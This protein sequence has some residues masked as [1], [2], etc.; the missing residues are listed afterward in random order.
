MSFFTSCQVGKKF[1]SEQD[2][3]NNKSDYLIEVRSI[4]SSA[5][6]TEV[7]STLG[8]KANINLIENNSNFDFVDQHPIQIMCKEITD[9]DLQNVLSALGKCT[10]ILEV[11]H[12]RL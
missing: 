2:A 10:G 3:T 5:V 6:I 1:Q 9:A 8:S 4:N 12:Y 11:I 7:L